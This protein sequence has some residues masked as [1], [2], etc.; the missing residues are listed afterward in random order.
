MLVHNNQRDEATDQ[1][2]LLSRCTQSIILNNCLN[3]GTAL[4]PKNLWYANFK[5]EK[6]AE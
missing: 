2:R 1:S 4:P 6:A 5:D 3:S